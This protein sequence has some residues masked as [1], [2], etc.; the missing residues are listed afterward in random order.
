VS[1]CDLNS[2]VFVAE[3]GRILV[4]RVSVSAWQLLLASWSLLVCV[5]WFLLFFVLFLSLILL[6]LC[7]L[8]ILVRFVSA[9]CACCCFVCLAGTS[10]E[11]VC[12]IV[13]QNVKSLTKCPYPNS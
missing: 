9:A 4:V 3:F 10:T 12:P 2:A 11:S 5:S 6:R 13:T 1:C 7:M 8:H